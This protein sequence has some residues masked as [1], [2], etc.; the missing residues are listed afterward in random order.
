MHEQRGIL[1]GI[2]TCSIIDHRNFDFNSKLSQEAEARSFIDQT[3]INAHLNKLVHEK[4]L[5]EYTVNSLRE[6]AKR[7]IES[8]KFKPYFRGLTYVPLEIV[9]LLQQEF[10]DEQSK[11]LINNR[12]EGLPDVIKLFKKCWPSYI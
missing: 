7:S 12:E 6:E 3:D 5:S 4:V 8:I 11:V 2:D 10:F 1:N 9:M